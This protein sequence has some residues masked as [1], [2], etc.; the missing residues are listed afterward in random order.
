MTA[1]TALL[2]LLLCVSPVPRAARTEE[3]R[4]AT[5]EP[6]R[7]LDVYFSRLEALGFSGTAL[8][9]RGA[10]VILGKGYGWADKSR[11]RRMTA[12]DVVDLGSIAKQ[13]TA[14]AILRLEADGK[15]GTG[16][17]ITRFFKDVPP[18]KRGITLHHL[19]TH[20]AGLASDFAES[21]Y[22]PVLRDEYVRRAL[23]SALLGPPG[24]RYAYSNAGFSLLA[25]VVELVSGKNYEAYLADRLFRPTGMTE[26]GYK[27][28]GWPRSGSPTAI[29]A[30]T[31]GGR[32]FLASVRP[33]RLIGRFAATA[34]SIRP[35][36]TWRDGTRRWRQTACCRRRPAA[37]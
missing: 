11:G 28:P 6:G 15:L 12:A 34:E 31:T 9:R 2:G 7:E 21:D 1:R 30:A 36:P 32:S 22:E 33:T 35:R 26:T 10:E 4:I 16:D 14:A 37:S 24:K 25:A 20:S 27:L 29:P 13:F 3:L 18:D 23:A 5:E 8:V 19:L 17:P